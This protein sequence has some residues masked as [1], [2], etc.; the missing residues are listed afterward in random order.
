MSD[1]LT[2][3]VSTPESASGSTTISQSVASVSSVAS[4]APG[5]VSSSD[6]LS[7]VLLLP[8]PKPSKKKRKPGVNT[9]AVCLTDA[10]VVKTLEA[11]A[12]EKLL[13]EQEQ[14]TRRIER[15]RKKKE[16][17]QKKL[18]TSCILVT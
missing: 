17:E 14:N 5:S 10:D 7:E 12:E 15:E 1:N 6:V 8:P 3:S 11:E 9:K 13:K 16:R 18:Y 2:C 4:H